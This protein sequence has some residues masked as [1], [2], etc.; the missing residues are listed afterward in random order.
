MILNEYPLLPKDHDSKPNKTIIAYGKATFGSSMT[1]KVSAPTKQ[2]TE[3]IRKSAR[4]DGQT[5]FVYVD[6][7]LTS[8][9]CNQC[10][11][12][13]LSDAIDRRSL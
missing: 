13:T 1:G 8:Q 5:K 2:I 9:L 6:D 4:Q 10:K 3:T 12:R 7:Y 11:T